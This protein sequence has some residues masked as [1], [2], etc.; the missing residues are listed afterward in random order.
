MR[1]VISQV[2]FLAGTQFQVLSCADTGLKSLLEVA[3]HCSLQDVDVYE[4]RELAVEYWC[5]VERAL[6]CTYTTRNL[7]LLELIAQQVCPRPQGC[8]GRGEGNPPPPPAY[9]QPVSL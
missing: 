9:A 4:L 1:P 2:L 5:D 8:I 7:E 6:P 3:M